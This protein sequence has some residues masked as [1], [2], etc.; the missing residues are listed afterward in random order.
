MQQQKATL[1]K[2]REDYVKKAMV[3]RRELDDMKQ[4][5]QDLSS[6]DMSER[7]MRFVFKENDRL[8]VKATETNNSETC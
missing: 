8:Q 1:T 6:G 5:K 4:Q 2:Q 7:E 3:L